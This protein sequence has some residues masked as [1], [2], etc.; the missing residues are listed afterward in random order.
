[1]P[2]KF[3]PIPELTPRQLKRFHK[4]ENKRG[5]KDC[6]NWIGG[7]GDRFGHGGFSINQSPFYAH[8]VAF[9]L[10]HKQIN[11]NLLV[12]HKCDN[13]SCVNPRH[14]YQGSDQDNANDKLARG[15][16][17][18]GSKNGQSKL[19]EAQ[20]TNI[21]KLLNAGCTVPQIL[22]LLK[23]QH[24]APMTLYNIK[25]NATWQWVAPA[26]IKKAFPTNKA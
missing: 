20:A 18:K 2:T 17:N 15:R 21:K 25:N 11:N 1:M 19:T 26:I 24:I 9:K 16:Q 23:L 7:R 14:L 12:C 22:T 4:Y 3:K 13:P 5:T 10:H 8:R 6:W